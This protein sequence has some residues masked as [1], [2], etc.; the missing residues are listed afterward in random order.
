M[1]QL[2][3]S[4]MQ[5]AT[6]KAVLSMMLDADEQEKL[7]SEEELKVRKF[8]QPIEIQILSSLPSNPNNITLTSQNCNTEKEIDSFY[9]EI[10]GLKM[11]FING[12]LHKTNV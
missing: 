6:E 4:L 8:K 12:N 10:P 1:L 3:D 9:S 7:F 5:Q 2:K 11:L